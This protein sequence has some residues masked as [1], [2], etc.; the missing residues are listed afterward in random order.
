MHIQLIGYS[1]TQ[2]NTGLAGTAL[3]GDS[4]QIANNQGAE[5]PRIIAWWAKNQTAGYHQLTSASAH[6][7]TRGL[8]VNVA[9][10]D[11]DQLLPIGFAIPIVP[12][13]T[14][15]LTLTGSNTAGDVEQ[16]ALLVHYPN[17]P[18]VSGRFIDWDE[19]H[20]RTR[21]LTTISATL[22]GA[23]AGYTGEELIQS[24]SDLLHTNQDYAVLGFS[25]NTACNSIYLR[26]PDTGNVKV[27][28]PGN[29]NDR[30]VMS[31][32]FCM[33][34]RAHG[35]AKTIPVINSGNRGQTYIGFQQ[36]EN[37][38]SPLVTMHLAELR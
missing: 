22:T 27:G 20:R 35:G 5:L 31:T 9:T 1:A 28:C 11:I 25:T 4:L 12:Q 10:T 17:L 13:E 23:A 24:E 26:G 38:V 2:P 6:D 16:G 8:R 36:D 19:C 3:T 30:D 32:F 37:N 15:A 21:A 34:S 33:L 14:L 18:G 7:T 29:A